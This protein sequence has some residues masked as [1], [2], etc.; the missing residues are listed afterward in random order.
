MAADLK[1][2][3]LKDIPAITELLKSPQ[4]EQWLKTHP[5]PVVTDCLRG[6][7]ASLR[8]ELLAPQTVPVRDADPAAIV[9]T[10][11]ADLLERKVAPQ[12]R[13]AINATG[14]ILHTGLGRAVLPSVW[15]TRFER[16]KGLLHA[17]G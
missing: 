16:V 12:L 6:A 2:D 15:W 9:L 4:A 1:H 11:A 10:R 5:L 17:G 7:V 14:I 3:L 8:Q 13:A